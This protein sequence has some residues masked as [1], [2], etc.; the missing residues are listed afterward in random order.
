MSSSGGRGLSVITWIAL[1]GVIVGVMS[2]VAVLGVM[3]G[4]EKE[5]TQK[6]LG[7]HAHISVQLRGG[8]GREAPRLSTVLARIEKTPQVASAMPVIYGEAFLLSATGASEGVLI[9]GVDPFKVREVL[10]LPSYLE[11]GNWEAFE[12]GGLILGRSLGSFLGVGPGETL[13][14]LL[15]KAEYTPFGLSPKM[16][17]LDVADLFYSGLSQFDARTAYLTLA[18]AERLFERTAQSIEVRATDVSQIQNL[19]ERLIDELQGD[20]RVEDWLSQN[21]G[22]LSALRLEKLVM[23]VI[24]GLIILV[25]AFNICGSLIMIVRDKTKDIAII[26]S[27]GAPNKVILRVF[28]IQGLFIGV[29][30]TFVGVIFGLIASWILDKWVRFPLDPSVYMIDRVPVD[31]R[32]GDIILVIVGAMLISCL[33]TLYPARL[34]SRL[35]P[36]KGLKYE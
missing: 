8:L 31:T 10:D 15:N 14:L 6:M 30:G 18:E 32:V 13:T 29:V 12:S 34:A 9:K 2:L 28:F 7:N 4:F 25:A 23:G 27:M 5:L 11:G 17:R 16:R 20:A 21:A 35:E 22:L 19:K 24:L 26:K 3:S 36:T 33:A 1:I